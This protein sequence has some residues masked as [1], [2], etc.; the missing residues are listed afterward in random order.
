MKILKFGGRSLANGEG[1][2]RVLS[3][4]ERFLLRKEKIAVVLSARG[5]TTDQL[6][7]FLE[8]AV[9]GLNIEEEWE[10]FKREQVAPRP[11]IDFSSEWQV[12]EQILQGVRLLGDLSPKVKDLFIAHGELLSVKLVAALLRD[13]GYEAQAVDSRIFIKTDEHFG[14]A[15]VEQSLSN[16]LTEDYF[17]AF[18]GI[19]I[20][21]GFIA[22]D[23]RGDTTTLGR[24]GSNYSASLLASFLEA[25]EVLSYTHINGVYSTNPAEVR[26]ARILPELHYKE[27]SE[28]ATFGAS[29]LHEKTIDPLIDKRI[30]LR[31][32]NTFDEENEGTLIHGGNSKKPIRSV[33]LQSDKGMLNLK[34]DGLLGK[35]GI[36]GRIFSTLSTYGI[37]VGI[38][39]QGS[40]EEGISF[41]V[42]KN[43]LTL[44]H[45]IL[46]EE[47]RKEISEKVIYRIERQDNI[48]ILNIT[49]LPIN[50]FSPCFNAL[51]RNNIELLLVN[52]NFDG[53]NLSI[54]VRDTQ[55]EKALRLV[56]QSILEDP[57][58][59]NL[60]VL[61]AG[62]VAASFLQQIV[63]SKRDWEHSYGCSLNVYAIASSRRLLLDREIDLK[64]WSLRLEDGLVNDGSLS[65]IV[66]YAKKHQL[67]NLVL[68]DCTAS[69]AVVED[70]SYLVKNGFSIVAANKAA[71]TRPYVKW[72]QFNKSLEKNGQEFLFGTNVGAALPV[73]RTLRGIISSGDRVKR[74]RGLFSGS[75]SFVFSAMA[76]KGLSFSE[77]VCLAMAKGYTEPDPRVD[78]SGNDIAKKLLILARE[79]GV[80]A[81]LSDII[82]E[83]LLPEQMNDLNIDTFLAQLSECNDQFIYKQERLGNE[84][85]LKYMA[86]L[87]FEDLDNCSLS[88][89]L[90]PVSRRSLIGQLSGSDNIFEIFT[91]AYADRPLCISGAGAGAAVT[92]RGLLTDIFSLRMTKR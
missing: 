18:T 62:Q 58:I 39:S 38:I 32:L 22:S 31:I 61:G 68:V 41:V 75:L 69:S 17:S 7:R 63:A 29:I 12:L 25:N 19:P 13:K 26:E 52:N 6:E 48:S 54:V 77:S 60:A 37:S 49:G 64:G 86:E 5:A 74:I 78:L 34:G 24:N 8:L 46:L 57:K 2:D 91:E 47:F 73:I 51:K 83:P 79:I 87:H 30:P 56:H 67:E 28:M 53:S 59:I 80:K 88:V 14:S 72:E 66:G 84:K 4:I 89:K 33:I 90:V 92:A 85:V 1:I 76:D 50:D 23:K 36:D 45:N 3:I 40:S 70:Y 82:V 55:G 10:A 65:Q 35:V 15:N 81:D 44:A 71:A 20:I 11:E 43:K 16:R 27:A 42:A 9:L 21:T